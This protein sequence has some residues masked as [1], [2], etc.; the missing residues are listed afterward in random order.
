MIIVRH[1]MHLY[2]VIL[3]STLS[4]VSSPVSA[5]TVAVSEPNIHIVLATLHRDRRLLTER[6]TS[7]KIINAKVRIALIAQC[8]KSVPKVS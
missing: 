5:D 3:A 2:I 6:L 4:L 8:A 7:S 1:R